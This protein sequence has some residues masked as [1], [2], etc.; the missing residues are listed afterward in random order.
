MRQ[1]QGTA[2]VLA[3][4]V[5][6]CLLVAA[7]ASAQ[8][9]KTMSYQGLLLGPA[10]G[11]VTDASYD[12]TFKL[13]DASVGGTLLWTEAHTGGANHIPVS[14]GIFSTVLGSITPLNLP[15]D[16]PYWLG[17]TVGAGPELTPRVALNSSAYA[18]R[19][20]AL[21]L[22]YTES[23]NTSSDLLFLTNNGTGNVLS[24]ILPNPPNSGHA[25]FGAASGTGGATDIAGIYGFQNSPGPGPRSSGVVGDNFEVGGTG[26]GVKGLDRGAGIGVY[27]TCNVG[28]GVYGVT[29]SGEAIHGSAPCTATN[30]VCIHGDIPGPTVGNS[31]SAVRGSNGGTAGSGIGVW[32]SQAGSG[33]GVYG[34]VTGAGWGVR[35]IAGPGGT[36][37]YG[38]GGLYAGFF[39]GNV[40]VAGNLVVSGSVTKGSGSFKIDHPL[41]PENKYLFHSFVESPDM[42]DMYDGVATTDSDGEA[43]VKLPDWFQAL[44]QDFRYQLTVM[45]QFAQAIV[46][47]KIDGNRFVIRTDKPGVEVSWQV[48][49]IRHDAT[50]LAHRIKVEVPKPESERGLYLDPSAYGKGPERGVEYRRENG[51]QAS[52]M[53]SNITPESGK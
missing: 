19:A 7:P 2:I 8:T 37:V 33:Y 20:R 4:L 49:G 35:G 48:T 15:F 38:G 53:G 18:A 14:K 27:G 31:S 42:K 50:A 13:Y 22:P 17:I 47:R 16:K 32:G 39:S 34:T 3:L 30:S 11:A 10:G 5:A 43:E 45:G 29:V 52:Q 9:P 46:A 28:T 36:G 51:G 24:A 25:I 40:T 6:A 21:E 1:S 23:F 12:L 41:D 26:Y 44:N